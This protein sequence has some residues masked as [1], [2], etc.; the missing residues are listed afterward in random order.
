MKLMSNLGM[1]PV[2]SPCVGVCTLDDSE[3]CVGCHRTAHEIAHWLEFSDG[4][5]NAIMAALEER[6]R[7]RD[8][9]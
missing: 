7:H 6:A 1:Q 3:L 2:L 4:E 8:G 9:A 5:R